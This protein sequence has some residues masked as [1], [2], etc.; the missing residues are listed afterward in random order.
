MIGKQGY[1]VTTY[2]IDG[3]YKD[4]RRPD[5]VE[6][7][8]NLKEDLKRRDFTINAM[9]YSDSKGIIDLFG[10]MEDLENGIIR[11]V[12]VASERF[13]EDA[14]RILRGI[15]FAGQ[16]GFQIE[17]NTEE[18]M[19]QQAGF[20][21]HISAERIHTELTKLLDSSHPEKLITAYEL[22]I[23][24]VILPEFDE[25]MDTTQNNPYH[26]Y[27]VGL[28]TMEVIKAIKPEPVFRYAA[29][30]HDVG[31]P[32]T[33]NTGSDGVDHFY[34]HGEVGYEIARTVLRRLKF[35]NESL[36]LILKMVRWHDYGVGGVPS[37]KS[38]RKALS[39][40]GADFFPYYAEIKRADIEGQNPCKREENLANLK[41][42]CE[43]YD[44]IIREGNCLTIKDLAV[45][46][47]DLIA[48]GIKPGKEIGEEL[49]E[50]LNRV[51]EN[52]ELNRRDI[53][54]DIV[55]NKN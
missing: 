36:G 9:A 43:M 25:M 11:A 30:L 38:F 44:E 45:N 14:L 18:A 16:L 12:G 51:L 55:K 2:R 19:R 6:F 13:D 54:I 23:T 26:I 53:L 4:H 50:L 35:D 17:K 46:G 8:A 27:S 39:K 21:A 31:K 40:M 20:L 28:H 24:K 49:E 22:G 37:L 29:L 15:R 5:E 1:E 10:G 33:K 41:A 47:K 52:P 32:R 48:L 42:L 3:E 7:T 34:G